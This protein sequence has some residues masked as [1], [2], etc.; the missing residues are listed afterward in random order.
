MGGGEFGPREHGA[1]LRAV[2]MGQDD[3]VAG[4]DQPDDR[5]GRLHGILELFLRGPLLARPDE[6]IASHRDKDQ[7]THITPGAVRA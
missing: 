6:G 4:L 7:L 2:A 3:T 1:H 5:V